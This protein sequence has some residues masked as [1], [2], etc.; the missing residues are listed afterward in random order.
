MK[1]NIA[2]DVIISQKKAKPLSLKK[3]YVCQTI[4]Q[5]ETL[6]KIVVE[7]KNLL[8]FFHGHGF[9]NY[10]KFIEFSCCQNMQVILISQDDL[11]NK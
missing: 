9:T 6:P 5:W 10:K 8:S 4:F 11:G 2:P 1:K 7:N 3:L